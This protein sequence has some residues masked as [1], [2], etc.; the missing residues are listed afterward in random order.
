MD[1]HMYAYICICI[2]YT[3][4]G[5]H[6]KEGDLNRHHTHDLRNHRLVLGENLGPPSPEQIEDN[7][8]GR[9]DA[10]ARSD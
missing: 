8:G 2:T 6:D 9:R 10:R 7:A 4:H 3:L 1:I 5:V